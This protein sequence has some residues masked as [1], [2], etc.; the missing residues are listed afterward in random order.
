[1]SNEE[2]RPLAPKP[3]IEQFMRDPNRTREMVPTKPQHDVD[4]FASKPQRA[5]DERIRQVERARF[6]DFYRRRHG[7]AINECD[8]P[9]ELQNQQ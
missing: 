1:M 2:G 3:G 5:D 4:I 8:Y 6:A 9:S 7:R